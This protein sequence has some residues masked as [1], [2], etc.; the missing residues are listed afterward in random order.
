MRTLKA[1]LVKWGNSNAVRILRVVIERVKL[2]EGDDLRIEVEGGR[3][4]IEPLIPKLTLDSLVAGITA[5]NTHRE[6]D[7]GKPRGREVR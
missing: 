3:I 5:K 6:Q 1:Q 4:I 2:K 7:W